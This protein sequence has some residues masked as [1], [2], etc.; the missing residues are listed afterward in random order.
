MFV[1][2][3]LTPKVLASSCVNTDKA[4]YSE[5]NM[6]GI[7]ILTLETDHPGTSALKLL[8]TLL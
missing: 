8:D 1:R 5:T 7:N 3:A 6:H 4:I 2:V